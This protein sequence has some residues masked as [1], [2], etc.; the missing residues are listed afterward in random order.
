MYEGITPEENRL[1]TTSTGNWTGDASWEPGP[2]FGESGILMI[3]RPPDPAPAIVTLSYPS[4]KTS[5]GKENSF[6]VLG[7]FRSLSLDL[8]QFYV[9]IT[10]GSYLFASPLLN[11][12][13]VDTWMWLGHSADIPQDWN[14]NNTSI[15]IQTIGGF[16]PARYLP[17]SMASLSAPGEKIQYLPIMGMG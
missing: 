12:S 1:F 4:V 16:G 2:I 7:I 17:V 15:I 8:G 11:L 14:N 10:D 9:K 6:A 13:V 3:M 5:K